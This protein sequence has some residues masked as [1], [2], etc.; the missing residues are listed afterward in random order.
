MDKRVRIVAVVLMLLSGGLRA[1]AA[2]RPNLSTPK[3]AAKAFQAALLKGDA[4]AARR[5]AL[6]Q[7]G[8]R[9]AAAALARVS[10]TVAQV[11][12]ACQ[13]KF[14]TSLAS[15]GN[16]KVTLRLPDPNGV[17]YATTTGDDKF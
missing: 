4:E 7:P 8:H 5:C 16:P 12:A 11:E 1:L 9:E 14:N 6:D 2:E 10:V 17:N 3:E 15:T 13:K